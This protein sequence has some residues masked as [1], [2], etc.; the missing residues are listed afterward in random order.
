M[1]KKTVRALSERE[2]ELMESLKFDIQ[3]AIAKIMKEKSISRIA[4]ADLMGVSPARI[5]KVLS[6]SENLTL[7]TI[8]RVF[9]ALDDEPCFNTKYLQEHSGKLRHKAY[10]AQNGWADEEVATDALSGGLFR[11]V[12]GPTAKPEKVGAGQSTLDAIFEAI[13]NHSDD[14]NKPA[15]DMRQFVQRPIAA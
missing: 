8:G 14:L 6:E 2:I 10:A 1:S 5:T 13:R 9:A 12:S 4:L 3:Y 15:N 7:E 11:Q